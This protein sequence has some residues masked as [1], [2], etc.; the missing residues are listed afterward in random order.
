MK[1]ISIMQN[2]FCLFRKAKETDGSEKEDDYKYIAEQ[3]S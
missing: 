1:K 3:F 2:S